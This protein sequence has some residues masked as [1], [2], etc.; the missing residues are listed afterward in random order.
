[1]NAKRSRRLCRR[2]RK[3]TCSGRGREREREREDFFTPPLLQ[4]IG[5]AVPPT[6]TRLG[7]FCSSHFLS[8]ADVQ[9]STHR[10]DS[11]KL[12]MDVH[13]SAQACIY[14]AGELRR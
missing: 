7:I 13:I 3:K 5:A 9:P 8:A 4:S 6:Q 12:I 14:P 2:P 11:N 10:T 1:M